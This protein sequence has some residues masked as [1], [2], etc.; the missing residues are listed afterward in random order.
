[1]KVLSALLGL[2]VA[3]VLAATLTAE[4]GGTKGKKVTKEG[5]LVCGKC[6]LGETDKCSNVLQV[7]EG[8]KTVNYYLVD[9]GNKETYHKGVCPPN[10][11]KEAT[12]SGTLATKDGKNFITPAAA[13]DVKVK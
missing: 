11:M 7:K 10:S 4:A 9:K 3:I 5:T 2:V 13:T 1:M 6:T 12:V 8:G